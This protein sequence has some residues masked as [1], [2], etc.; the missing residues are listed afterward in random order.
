MATRKHG[1]TST[2]CAICG[3]FKRKI[4]S[5]GLKLCGRCF[6]ERA[7]KLGFKKFN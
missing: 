6:R 1:K 3:S 2:A 7:R 5:F 4:D